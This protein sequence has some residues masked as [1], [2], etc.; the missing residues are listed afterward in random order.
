MLNL[1]QHNATPEQV[2]Q[3]V[4]ELP[5]D[6]KEELKKLLTFN[7]LEETAELNERAYKIARIA[8]EH[9]AER[10][11]IGGAPFFMPTL[12]SMLALGD[13][14]AHYAFS[15]R[16]VVETTLPN[17]SVEKKAIFKHVGFVPPVE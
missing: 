16:E 17:G 9:G 11:M 12:E 6:V 13:I 2:A 7:T 15:Q 4:V 10:A 5:S 3:G 8:K 1:T 14:S